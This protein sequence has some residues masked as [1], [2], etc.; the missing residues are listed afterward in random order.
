M[1]HHQN[2]VSDARLR[3]E[4]AIAQATG[5]ADTLMQLDLEKA[6]RISGPSFHRMAWALSSML[7][8]AGDDL[9]TVLTG[10]QAPAAEASDPTLERT[11]GLER[12]GPFAVPEHSYV[13]AGNDLYRAQG[14]LRT[15]LMAVS[16]DHDLV[17]LEHT[18]RAALDVLESGSKEAFELARDRDAA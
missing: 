8:Q 14:L 7:H 17:D 4:D 12:C 13:I 5:L 3:L 9:A 15:V 6:D 10:D 18:L 1:N 2:R 16:E 11:A